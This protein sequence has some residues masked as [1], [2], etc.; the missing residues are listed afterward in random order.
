MKIAIISKSDHLGGGASRVATELADLLLQSKHTV[1]HWVARS[2][3]HV[4]HRV[5]QLYGENQTLRYGIGIGHF[6]LRKLGA[7]E[8]IP[9]ERLNPCIQD[10]LKAD[11]IHVHDITSAVSIKTLT[12]LAAQKPVVW[13]LHDCSPFTGGCI[14]PLDCDKFIHSCGNCPHHDEWP[15][16]GLFDFTRILHAQKKYF[17]INSNFTTLAPSKWMADMAESSCFFPRPEIISNG[18]DLATFRPLSKRHLKERLGIDPNRPVIIICASNLADKRKGVQKALEVLHWSKKLNPFILAIGNVQP[19]IKHALV[20]FDVTFTGFLQTRLELAR[21]YSAGDAL[22][23]FTSAD[24]Q[25]LTVMEAMACGTPIIGFDSGG[26]PELVSHLDNG[27]LI[28]RED[29]PCL[30]NNICEI[31]SDRS[32]LLRWSNNA[33][34]RASESFGYDKFL[35]AHLGVYTRVFEMRKKS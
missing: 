15:L 23:F 27:Y 20:D 6:M 34:L 21:W 16:N 32:A 22:L 12:W 28:K 25:P 26:M 14:Y 10:L 4:N 24:N 31:L 2:K 8:L 18:I 13:T 35:Q 19:A 7:P 5:Y 11:L 30:K 9:I 17:A 29:F 1:A 3:G 33:A